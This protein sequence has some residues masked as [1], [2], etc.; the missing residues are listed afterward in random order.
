[1][2]QASAGDPAGPILVGPSTGSV[3]YGDPMVG[4][5][6]AL[7]CG[8]TIVELSALN[9]PELPLVAAAVPE[10]LPEF[11]R[12]SVHG[13]AKGRVLD[14]A[15]LAGQLYRLGCDV[16]MHPGTFTP[17]PSWARLGSRLLV[18]NN[19]DRKTC[20]RTVAE[21]AVVFAEVPDAGFCLD[22]SHA[23]HVGGPGYAVKLALV[24]RAR[25]T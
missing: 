20:G 14:D 1:M 13:P 5:A 3:A 7:R 16:V 10:A 4:V 19:D 9:E 12:V 17:S 22:V 8:A 25:L 6:A 24:F 18:E 2:H 21:L 23:L 11:M 15:V